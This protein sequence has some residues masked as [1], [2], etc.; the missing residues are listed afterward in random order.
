[1]AIELTG[2]SLEELFEL[3]KSTLDTAENAE[4]VAD[5]DAANKNLD[6][7]IAQ[8]NKVSKDKCY[9]AC[10]NAEKPLAYAILQFYYE[11]IRIK[12][13]KEKDT[14]V[15]I[16]SIE[17]TRR[18][19]DIS[20]LWK[21]MKDHEKSCGVDRSWY[22]YAEKFNYLMTVRAAER[23]GR[24]ALKG[25]FIK[26]A[27]DYR[28]GQI[29]KD[30]DMGKTP[31]SNTNILRTLQKLVTAM[32]G[33]EWKATSRD[34]NLLCDL[35]VKDNPRNPTGVKLPNHGNFRALL[36]KVCYRILTKGEGYDVESPNFDTEKAKEIAEILAGGKKDSAKETA[37]VD[38]QATEESAAE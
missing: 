18:P 25:L 31:C 37:P 9:L 38:E 3:A 36:K 22:H 33:N 15:V 21:W 14:D 30:F 23:L 28:M 34:V 10:R 1:M 4:A 7:I 12:E 16:R 32:L 29:A 35:Y 26:Y 2:K 17:R 24:P 11:G 8:Y 6:A 5:K 19:I 13:E 20:N 27:E